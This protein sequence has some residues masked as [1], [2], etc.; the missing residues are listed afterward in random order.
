MAMLS[1]TRNR[2]SQAHPKSGYFFG[3]TQNP[4]MNGPSSNGGRSSL[5]SGGSLRMNMNGSTKR[6]NRKAVRY[7]PPSRDTTRND[8]SPT[9][10]TG[11]SAWARPDQ[12]GGDTTLPDGHLVGDRGGESG[13]RGVDGELHDQPDHGQRDDA[14][15]VRHDQ[16]ADH[17]EDRTAEHPRPTTAEAGR[18]AVG[19]GAGQRVPDDRADHAD[20][21]D[22]GQ[23]GLFAVRACDLLGQPGQQVEDR[24]EERQHDAEVGQPQP[25]E[26]EP[27]DGCGRFGECGDGCLRGSGVTHGPQGTPAAGRRARFGYSWGAEMFIDQTIPNLSVSWP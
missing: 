23:R 9:P 27:S 26:E 25:G 8:T 12:A 20:A 19:H 6:K 16:Q 7:E 3:D 1:E 13:V 14:R 22:D 18:G 15:H 5:S 2:A 10:S 17:A 24:R 11:P 4:L 21:G